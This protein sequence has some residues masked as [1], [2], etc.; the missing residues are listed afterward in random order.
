MSI[1]KRY[2]FW[3]TIAFSWLFTYQSFTQ[4]T[5]AN[6]ILTYND[7]GGEYTMEITGLPD[8]GCGDQSGLILDQFLFQQGSAQYAA[9]VRAAANSPQPEHHLVD[10]NFNYTLTVKITWNSTSKD[11]ESDNIDVGRIANAAQAD[12]VTV[13]NVAWSSA[14]FISRVGA[15]STYQ[16]DYTPQ[17]VSGLN[18]EVILM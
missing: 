18:S 13:N 16:F 7:P 12:F 10:Q 4:T 6:G 15:T 1:P 9:Q 11:I 2:L 14:T 17:T 3:L 8:V 5:S